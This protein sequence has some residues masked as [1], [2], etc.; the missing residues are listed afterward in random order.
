MYSQSF[1]SDK[2]YKVGSTYFKWRTFIVF[3]ISFSRQLT[4]QGEKDQYN[5]SFVNFKILFMIKRSSN[6]I[7][8][9]MYIRI[10]LT[11]RLI[12]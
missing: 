5:I 1:S 9:I 7:K 11:K 3:Y 12:N 6:L 10:Y 4:K 2:Y 8:N